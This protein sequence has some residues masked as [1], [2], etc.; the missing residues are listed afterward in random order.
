ME[1]EQAHLLSDIRYIRECM[2]ISS[3][4]KL[5]PGWAAVVGGGLALAAAAATWSLTG[6]GD[7]QQVLYLPPLRKLGVTALW[8]A[9][10]SASVLLYWV[11]AAAESRRLG[12][13]LN[14]RPTR[15]ARQ[16][17]GPSVLVAAVLTLRLVF[18]RQYDLVP[19][20]WMLC[21]GVGVYNAGLFSSEEPRLLGLAV[22]VTGIV[23]LLALPG[24]G[25]WTTGLSF[26]LYHVAFGAYVLAR[27]RPG[28]R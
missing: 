12:V 8:A 10:G 7:V 18:D 19:G 11:L 4:H 3:Q 22:L 23:A 13:S 15:L 20:V 5:L 26:G 9:A 2:E 25:L 28:G 6:S 1:T 17:M 24:F 27:R 14:A 16:A 21:Y